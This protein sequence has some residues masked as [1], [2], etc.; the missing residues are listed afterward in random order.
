M[1]DGSYKYFAIQHRKTH[2][3]PWLK[4][5]EPLVPVDQKS[6]TW[7]FSSW[8]YFGGY[9]EPWGGKGNDWKP[10]YLKSYNETHDVW[11]K[12]GTHGWWSLKYAIEGIKRL[13]QASC[14]G[15]LN[16]TDSYGKVTQAV[17]FDFRIVVVEVSRK[18][19]EL[20][21]DTVLDELEREVKNGGPDGP[22]WN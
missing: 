7:S 5:E 3:S 4:P 12:T 13:K 11:S 22:S 1:I 2:E 14:S 9:A 16:S 20:N 15:K 6:D 19:S 21:M 17:R 8:D 18:V 10:L